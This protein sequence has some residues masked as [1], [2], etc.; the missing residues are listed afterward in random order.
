MITPSSLPQMLP[1]WIADDGVASVLYPYHL[2][3]IVV[4]PPPC[5]LPPC[6]PPLLLCDVIIVV[7][8]SSS[9]GGHPSLHRC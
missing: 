7:S 4:P 2:N 5:P 9:P 1:S 8:P 3:S 6:S